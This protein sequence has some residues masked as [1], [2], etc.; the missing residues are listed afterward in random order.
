MIATNTSELI[1]ILQDIEQE[2]KQPIDFEINLDVTV[3]TTEIDIFN[4]FHRVHF[5]KTFKKIQ[6]KNENMD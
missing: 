4:I 1:K 3:N 5:D 6:K 2:Y